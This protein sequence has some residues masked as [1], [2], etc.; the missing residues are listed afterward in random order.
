MIPPP[1]VTGSLHMGHAFKNTIMDTLIRY[2][3]MSGDTDAVA[4]G[5]R[6]RR[7]R[8]P[9]GGRAPAG[10]RGQDPP[11]PGP[12]GLRR[13]RLGVEGES[14]GTITRQ[15]RRLGASLDWARERFTMDEGLSDAVREVFVRLYE[16]GLIYRGKRLVNWDP[17]LHTAVS[18]LEV[19]SEEESGHMWHMRY[20]ARPTASGHLVVATT[21]PE[22]MLGDSAV[23]V[24]P[25]DERYQHLIGELVELP[26]TGRRIP[27]I[28]DEYVDPEFG[29]GCVKITPA[30]DFN[31]YEVWQR[32]RDELPISR[33]AHGGLINIFTA[34][35][36]IR[37]NDA[38]EGELIPAA[39][40]G[41]DRFEARKRIVAD[42]EAAGPAGEDRRSQADG[43][44][45]RPL[46]RGHRAV[47]HRPV[48]RQG[49]ARWPKPAIEAVENGRHPLRA[50]E[51]GEHLLR[52]DAQHPGLVH[53]PPDLVGPSHPGLVRRPRA[54]S[55]SAAA[56][57]RCAPSTSS[58]PTTRCART[59]TC[60]TPGSRS[61]LWPFSTLG[62]P[63]ET[64]R[65]K[66]F[67]PTSV[68]V[69]GF[70]IIFFWVAR[71]IMMG[72]KFMGEVPFREVYIHGLVRD[73]QGQKMSKSK[74]NVLDPIDL[75]DGIEL[76]ALVAKRTG[77]MMQPQLAQEDREADA[78]GV[79]G[80]HP[81]LR[82][83]RAALHLRRPGRDR[84]RHQVR[85]GA[86]RGLPQLLQQALER[87]ALRADER[88]RPGLRP[89]RR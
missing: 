17:E 53:Q 69:T 73:A 29:T 81:G 49:R 25:E 35:A 55:T 36:A 8:H 62:W 37:E 64:E 72:L 79:P 40:R 85:H 32:H 86:H 18:D 89:D 48:V 42:L 34:D 75:I 88:R 82:H 7:H 68:L 5:H 43:A 28:A 76:E 24:H 70:D 21:R 16:E 58:P 50:G 59:R 3:R 31:D 71:M 38:E 14:G 13:A 10:G 1:N 2:H 51:L 80:R 63:E 44:A 19:V 46:R 11:R 56:R 20:P 61:A 27:I 77:G 84:A 23:A 26:L 4:A 33:Q 57:P 54:T 67:Y 83:R 41:L 12:R 6:P 78:Q 47:P 87:R 74:G 60:S 52:V 30:H 66:H 22:T 9:D 39:Y 15:L 65:L 45:R